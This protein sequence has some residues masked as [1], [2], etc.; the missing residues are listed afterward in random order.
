[1]DWTD[2]QS[3]T[4]MVII[5]ITLFIFVRRGLRIWLLGKDKDCCGGGCGCEFKK[6]K[7]N[8]GS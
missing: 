1:M 3:Y 4:V 8:Q 7:K 2:W 5:G 6:A